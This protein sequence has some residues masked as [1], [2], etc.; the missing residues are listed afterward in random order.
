MHFRGTVFGCC[1]YN[2]FCVVI[3]TYFIV[4]VSWFNV[5]ESMLLSK[6]FTNNKIILNA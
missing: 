6:L 2:K 1:I 5:T 3:G 4:F